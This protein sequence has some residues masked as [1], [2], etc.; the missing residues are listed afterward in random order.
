MKQLTEKELRERMNQ[1]YGDFKE[2]LARARGLTVEQ[3]EDLEDTAFEETTIDG[4]VTYESKDS[5]KQWGIL[6]F[7]HLT[8]WD[9]TLCQFLEKGARFDTNGRLKITLSWKELNK[10]VEDWKEKERREV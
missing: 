10:R 5:A 9:E 3:V 7:H 2:L 8:E 1:I 4:N 6:F